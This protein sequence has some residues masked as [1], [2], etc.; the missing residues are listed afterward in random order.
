MPIYVYECAA[1]GA[2]DEQLILKRDAAPDPCEC[3]S[4]D[5]RK[6]PTT[7]STRFVGGGWG[8]NEEIAGGAATMRVVQ[9]D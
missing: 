3:G 6:L 7:A 1:C 2:V 5:L 4:S 8:G 9:G